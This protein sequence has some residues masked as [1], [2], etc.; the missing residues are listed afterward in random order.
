MPLRKEF[1]FPTPIYYFDG[2][3]RNNFENLAITR[4]TFNW[5]MEVKDTV[6]NEGVSNVGG[7]QTPFNYDFSSIPKRSLEYVKE[8]L[9]ELPEYTLHNWW[10]NIS[11]K[12]SFN[13]HHTHPDMHLAL[14]WYLTPNY[15]T[16]K[17]EHPLQHARTKLHRSVGLVDSINY[18]CNAGDILVFPGDLLHCVKPHQQD[19][20][21]MSISMNLK[22]V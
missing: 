15:S 12:G 11:E 5:G 3:T 10:L 1:Y 4:N 8:A 6:P 7:Y 21:R 22:L 16:I 14:V 18:T 19:S 20:P 9:K 13:W 17:F 2:E